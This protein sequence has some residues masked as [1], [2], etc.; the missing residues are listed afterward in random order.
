MAVYY[1][2]RRN[3]LWAL[4]PT[5]VFLFGIFLQAS[6]GQ[7]LTGKIIVVDAGHGGVDS[8]ANRPGIAEKE[9]NL[10]IALQLRDALKAQEARVV[11]TR[12]AD[13]DLSGL[14]DSEQVRGRYRRDLNARLEM[15]QESD[16]DLFVSIHANTSLKARRRGFECYYATGM[17]AGKMLA[18]AIQDQLR[19]VAPISQ[20]AKPADYFVLRRNKVPA[21]LVE[22]GFITNTE[23]AAL[24]Q[25]AEYQRSLAKAIASGIVLYYRPPL[26]AIVNQCRA[27]WMP[28]QKAALGD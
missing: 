12:D 18:L 16:A 21:V 3:L 22:V 25:S 17:D 24:L 4:L 28:P 20:N 9:I 8:G 7:P 23:E 26:S 6:A 19:A 14:C 15:I 10:A 1:I 5:I 13:V 11:L 2:A 27:L